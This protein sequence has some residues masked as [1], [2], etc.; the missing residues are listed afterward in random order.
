MK[1]NPYMYPHE[2]LSNA[3][4]ALVR[5]GSQ[6]PDS[7]EGA[8]L[9]V[10]KAKGD[11]RQVRDSLEPMQRDFVDRILRQTEV[12]TSGGDPEPIRALVDALNETER[13]YLAREIMELEI[14]LREQCREASGK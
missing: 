1:P 3:V 10:L 5:A 4:I 7:L 8:I 2:K 9:E 6:N 12:N 11:L 14:A 13:W